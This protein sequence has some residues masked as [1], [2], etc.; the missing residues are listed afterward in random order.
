MDDESN[1][2]AKFISMRGSRLDAAHG[3]L[4]AFTRLPSA[5]NRIHRDGTESIRALHFQNNLPIRW[6]FPIPFFESTSQVNG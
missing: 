5:R 4:I 1:V 3:P 6:P 2:A